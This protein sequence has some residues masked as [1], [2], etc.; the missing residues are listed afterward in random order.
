MSQDESVFICSLLKVSREF[1]RLPCHD[2]VSEQSALTSG[3]ENIRPQAIYQT[4]ANV[5]KC[6]KQKTTSSL[7]VAKSCTLSSSPHVM[8]GT[9]DDQWNY[10]YPSSEG[11]ISARDCHKSAAEV[12]SSDKTKPSDKQEQTSVAKETATNTSQDQ[13]HQQQV[14][15]QNLHEAISALVQRDALSLRRRP[16]PFTLICPQDRASLQQ[17]AA[18]TLHFPQEALPKLPQDDTPLS[19]THTLHRTVSIPNQK[20][21]ANELE[22]LNIHSLP[23]GKQRR[24]NSGKVVTR[25]KVL[26]PRVRYELSQLVQ[27]QIHSDLLREQ[28]SIENQLLKVSSVQHLTAPRGDLTGSRSYP[29]IH[30]NSSSCSKRVSL[31]KIPSTRKKTT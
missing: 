18:Q 30:S 13:W 11:A 1:T 2:V 16:D 23:I 28:S 17:A 14:H 9:L 27:S 15:I 10:T 20:A 21:P 6:S 31:N 25:H 26:D 12:T 5:R 4:R 3:W 8:R 29:N 22:L 7:R 24:W 19:S